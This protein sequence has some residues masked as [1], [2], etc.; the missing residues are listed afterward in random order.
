MGRIIAIGINLQRAFIFFY[1]ANTLNCCCDDKSLNRDP[2]L[3]LVNDQFPLVAKTY[4][5]RCSQI[6]V[7]GF[8]FLNG[9]KL[10]MS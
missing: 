7:D 10:R 5:Y 6:G 3:E 8:G 1:V 2:S 9:L 4:H